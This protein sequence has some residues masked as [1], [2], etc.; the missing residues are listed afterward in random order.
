MKLAFLLTTLLL[1]TLGAQTSSHAADSSAKP[2]VIVIL[3][4]DAG[5]GDYSCHANPVAKTP[6]VDKLHGESVRFSDFHVTP[7]CTPTRSQLM[8]GVDNFRNGASV[9]AGS[10]MLL[11]PDLPTVAN[12]FAANGYRTGQF[13]KWHL[14][15]NYPF[16]PQDRGF[17]DVLYFN[18]AFVGVSDDTWC[19]D[20]VDPW[21]RH[22][23]GK[24]VQFKG[25]VD[26]ILFNEAMSWMDQR[27]KG[28]EPFFC[29]LPLA[30]VHTPLIVPEKYCE[31][32]KNQ[33]PDHR[34]ILGMLANLDETMGRLDAFL[35]QS[36]LR[37]N[38]ILV[39]LHDNGT[40]AMSGLYNAGMRGS[41]ATPWEGGHRSPLFVR[42]PSGGLR[43]PG[44]V[45]GLTQVQDL[46]P[47]LIGLCGLKQTLEA[48]F[49]GINL[50][51]VLQKAGQEPPDRILVVQ[52]GYP[53]KAAP[54]IDPA[55]K[56]LV[57]MWGRWR[58]VESGLY[59]LATDPGQLKDVSTKQPEIVAKLRTAYAQW[60]KDVEPWT[61][62][63][64][65]IIVGDDRENPSTLLPSTQYDQKGLSPAMVR[66]GTST[67]D[68][69]FIQVA[70]AGNYEIA[71]RRWPEEA[72][73]AIC[74]TVPAWNSVLGNH[75][76]PAG[77]AFPIVKARLNVGEF[78]GEKDVTSSDTVVSFTMPLKQ[79]QTMLRGTFL[80]DSGKEICGA[81]YVSVRRLDRVP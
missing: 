51:P 10:R 18:S 36:G 38:T 26:D 63:R 62:K 23:D 68:Q 40:A 47:T 5:Y 32:Y 7:F 72:N 45:S 61:T 58:L 33:K 59:D 55:Q 35:R 73:A 2:N 1:S 9:V 4:D 67:M 8:T 57:V 41:K 28:G 54:G 43:P 29:Y 80:D 44:E 66:A 30:L 77:K 15:D 79:G 42:W 74:G 19:N 17:Q 37:D 75:P 34:Q 52:H 6:N 78:K 25:Y 46:V 81:Y 65:T 31:P 22:A 21:L 24:P 27:R 16:R 13:G 76:L 71:L 14:G 53:R 20:Y 50:A 3:V 70:R 60:W 12:I 56:P 11:R 69:W 49:D 64:S 39:F 48:K